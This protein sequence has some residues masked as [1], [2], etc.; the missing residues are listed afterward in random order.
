M[1]IKKWTG[2]IVLAVGMAL[3]GYWFAAHNKANAPGTSETAPAAAAGPVA[4]VSVTPLRAGLIDETLS[5]YGTVVAAPGE[6]SSASAP[7]E[8]RVRKVFVIAG[9]E[10]SSNAPLL[11]IE[12]SP[13]T[14]LQLD[15]ARSERDSA[16][17][18]LQM[19][20][21]RIELKLATKPDLLAAQQRVHDATLRVA[22]L[23]QRGAGGPQIIRAT[24]G[25]IVSQIFA[26]PGQIVA[27]GAVLVETIGANQIAVRLGLKT[28]DAVQLQTGQVVRLLPVNS[29]QPRNVDGRVQLITQAVNSQ[30]RL[31]DIF[32]K[33]AADSHLL[34]NEYV[35]G[36]IVI[37]STN[38]L[39]VPRPAALPEDGHYVL[40]TV[41]KGHAVRHVVTVG[42]ENTKEV[43]VSGDGLAAGQP[44]VTVGNSQLQDGMAVEAGSGQ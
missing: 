24:A 27:A 44:V 39:I 15:Q 35:E 6:A 30:T 40:F 2:L 12:D 22:S 38:A 9:L 34:L 8:C 18:Q 21:Q 1:K 4:K 14:K 29:T 31:V 42:L 20:E 25:G 10:V 16:T 37:D 23:E 5:A 26:Q 7:Y 36:Q 3:G 33:P 41:D 28:Q 19:L 17:N 13:D 32:V 11:E 43:Q